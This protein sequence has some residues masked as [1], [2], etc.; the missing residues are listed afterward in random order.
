M[1]TTPTIRK[2]KAGLPY[3]DEPY[4]HG[5]RGSVLFQS[6]PITDK[7]VIYALYL[8]FSENRRIAHLATYHKKAKIRKKNSSRVCKAYRADRARRQQTMR[9]VNLC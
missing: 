3:S 1:E 6:K 5:S 8:S 4:I 9:L 7:R 2:L